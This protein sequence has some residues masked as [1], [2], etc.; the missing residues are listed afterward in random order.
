[1]EN[2]GFDDLVLVNPCKL[3]GQARAMSCHAHDLLESAPKVDTL[4]E[5]IEDTDIVIGTSGI[6]G[7]KTD[8]HIRM[9]AY[10]PAE[11]RDKFRKSGGKIA[12][13]FGRE[14]NGFTREELKRCDMIMTIPTSE[15]YPVMNISHAAT[16][17]MY[18]MSSL[19]IGERPIAEGFDL[20]LLYDHFDQLLAEIK[21][22]AH[23]MEKTS[24]MLKRIFG[25]AELTPREVQTLRGVLRDIQRSKK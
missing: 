16:V 11:I 23:K 14:D 21:H 8:Q 2:F 3:E 10:T 7:I 12:L 9:P 24:L 18:E 1:M 4:E 19:P 25:R 22:P 6:A 17:A 13:L 15:K 20:Q 5:A